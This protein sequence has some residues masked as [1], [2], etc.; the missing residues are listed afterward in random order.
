MLAEEF[1]R[2][3]APMGSENDGFGIGM[4]AN[5]LIQVGTEEQKHE[6]L[7][8]ILSGEHRWCQGFSEPE[9][10]SDLGGLRTRAVLD[11]G[12][13]VINGHKIWISAAHLADHIFVLARTD[14]DAPKHKGISLL[15]VPM[16][17]TGVVVTP[18]EV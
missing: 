3:G 15:L 6:Y 16:D 4:L 7:P 9:A 11:D 10:G 12:T 18:I 5:T 13:W 17:Q 1:A 14:V 8:K 2:A